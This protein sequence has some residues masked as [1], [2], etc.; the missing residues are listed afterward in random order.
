[1]NIGF[2]VSVLFA[3]PIMFFSARNNFIAIVK[4]FIAYFKESAE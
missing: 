1:M 4:L 2:L 3:Y